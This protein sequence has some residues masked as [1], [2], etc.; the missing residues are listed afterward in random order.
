MDNQAVNEFVDRVKVAQE[1]A[2]AAPAKA[3]NDIDHILAPKYQLRDCVYLDKSDITMTQPLRKLSHCH[4]GPFLVEQQV[5]PLAYWLH[6]PISLCQ[7]YPVFNV[8]KLFSAS[9]NPIPG[10]C[11]KP[12]P[13]SVLVNSK[14]QYKVEEILDSHL[15]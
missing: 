7:L 4:L 10:H 8:V 11:P 2:K 15:F 12:L 1:E 14:E 3:K 6:L 9:D 5:G 13:P